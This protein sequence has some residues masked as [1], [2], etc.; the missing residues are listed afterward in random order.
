MGRFSDC[1]E[2]QEN[3]IDWLMH[4]QTLPPT[5]SSLFFLMPDFDVPLC[6]ESDFYLYPYQ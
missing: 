6:G 2:E 5:C 1:E 4:S 3:I